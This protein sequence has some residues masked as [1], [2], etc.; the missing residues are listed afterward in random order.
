MFQLYFQ[1]EFNIIVTIILWAEQNHVLLNLIYLVETN[2]MKLKF[3]LEFP[4]P[5][6]IFDVFVG[7]FCDVENVSSSQPHNVVRV[8]VTDF[9]PDV[10]KC[11]EC[12]AFC[13]EASWKI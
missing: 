12:V 4:W 8:L 10:L 6:L 9:E 11:A 13:D 7:H 5:F 2:T 3:F 1:I